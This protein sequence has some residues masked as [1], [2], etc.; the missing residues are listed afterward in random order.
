M[1]SAAAAIPLAERRIQEQE[2]LISF[3]LTRNPG[4]IERGL[5]LVD[6]LTPPAVPA[7]LPSALLERRPDIRLSEQ[8]LVAE[9]AR[10]GEAK[11]LLLPEHLADRRRGI[12]ERGARRPVQEGLGLLGGPARP[13][14]A[15]LQRGAHR[16][17]HQGAAVAHAARPS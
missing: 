11:A 12:P 10:V 8:A 17:E 2:N 9:N 1:R 14:A 6:Q 16:R 7:G 15:D 4:P 3:L 5:P 13:R